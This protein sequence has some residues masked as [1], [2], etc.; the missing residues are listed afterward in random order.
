MVKQRVQVGMTL[1][2]DSL[3]KRNQKTS[4][5]NVSFIRKKCHNDLLSCEKIRF[6]LM[7]AH[8]SELLTCKLE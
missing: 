5:Q 1:E 7:I 4:N 8:Q 2:A 6:S 3:S